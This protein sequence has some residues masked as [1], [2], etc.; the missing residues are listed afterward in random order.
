MKTITLFIG[1]H[2]SE[3]NTHSGRVG[4]RSS[5]RPGSVPRSDFKVNFLSFAG[6]ANI[7]TEVGVV[8]VRESPA[9]Q[10]EIIDE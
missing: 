6:Y 8:F 9:A 3:P 5:D 7:R 10:E 2:G 4:T 1:A